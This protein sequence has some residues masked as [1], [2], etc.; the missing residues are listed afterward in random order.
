[1]K[2]IAFSLSNDFGAKAFCSLLK[3]KGKTENSFSAFVGEGVI[4]SEML[5]SFIKLLF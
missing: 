2:L 3:R 5:K 1:M 4:N